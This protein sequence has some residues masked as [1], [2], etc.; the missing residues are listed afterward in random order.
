MLDN[1]QAIV[2]EPVLLTTIVTTIVGVVGT[3]TLVIKWGMKKSDRLLDNTTDAIRSLSKAVEKIR[4]FEAHEN[5]VVSCLDS[6]VNTQL[7]ILEHIKSL[8]CNI[9]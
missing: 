9:R 2:S 5:R 4:S 8:E 6:I 1:P 7:K 3:Q